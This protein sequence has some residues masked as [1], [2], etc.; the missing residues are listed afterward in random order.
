MIN[1]PKN[2]IHG[3]QKLE[4]LILYQIMEQIFNNNDINIL[5]DIIGKIDTNTYIE[6]LNYFGTCNQINQ[7]VQARE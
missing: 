1:D 4:E 7:I 5:T 6:L 2:L 3:T